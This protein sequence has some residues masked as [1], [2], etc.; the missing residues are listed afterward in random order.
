MTD[1]LFRWHPGDSATTNTRSPLYR[2]LMREWEA[3][4]GLPTTATTVHRWAQLEPDLTDLG[5]PVEILDAIDGG[6]PDIK[7]RL[8]L[9]LIRLHQAGHHLAG[10][11]VLQ[12][13]LP[14]LAKMARSTAGPR[15]EDYRHDTLSEF[16][17]VLTGYPTTR[18]TTRVAAN[19]ALDTLHRLTVDARRDDHRHQQAADL[20]ERPLAGDALGGGDQLQRIHV[21]RHHD[22]DFTEDTHLTDV[23]L[24]AVA[25]Q[26]ITAEQAQLLVTCYLP[27]NPDTA[28][29]FT[30]AAR[31]LGLSE[32]A[33]RKRCSRISRTLATAVLA[34][35]TDPTG[36][37][38]ARSTAAA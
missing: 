24:W 35:Y 4:N 18:R 17:L 22:D 15:R 29:G 38:T 28:Y 8:L 13:M 6:D 37:D 3:L 27:A 33:I 23:L 16:W 7:D 14:K 32:T 11:T 12:A 21:D 1:T 5:S 34:H 25:H 30:T 10:R 31:Q 19:L 2:Q 26:V 9:A 36:A 20:G